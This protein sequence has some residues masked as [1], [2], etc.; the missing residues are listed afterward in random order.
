MGGGDIGDISSSTGRSTNVIWHKDKK[1]EPE[2]D[3]IKQLKEQNIEFNLLQ[4][5]YIKDQSSEVSKT[6]KKW[7]NKFIANRNAPH[8]DCYLWHI[9]SYGSTKYIEGEEATKEYLNQYKTKVLIFN[10][11]QQYLIECQ[12]TIPNIEMD[13]FFDD[14]YI[15]HHNMKWT[16]V[17]PHEIP[18]IGPYFSTGEANN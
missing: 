17:I 9:F 12:N 13:D 5:E 8:L 16:Y 18:D 14:I 2:D 11:P 6:V 7:K 3:I 4:K 15:C 10:E 1:M